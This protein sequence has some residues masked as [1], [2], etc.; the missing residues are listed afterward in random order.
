MATSR[1]RNIR[2]R[3]RRKYGR[4]YQMRLRTNYA[5]P[6]EVDRRIA[7]PASDKLLGRLAA[8]GGG[9]LF[10]G[11]VAKVLSVSRMDLTVAQVLTTQSSPS[12]V[13][14]GSLL[15]FF[16]VIPVVGMNVTL[17]MLGRSWI[18][19]SA[20]KLEFRS[21][22]H[23]IYPAAAFGLFTAL[24]AYLTPRDFFLQFLLLTLSAPLFSAAVVLIGLGARALS[25]RRARTFSPAKGGIHVNTR[26]VV[27]ALVAIYSI[28]TTFVA[29]P[30]VVND[31]SWLPPRQVEFENGSGFVGYEVARTTEFVT[32]LRE[33]NRKIVNVSSSTI[34]SAEPCRLESLLNTA[35]P[36]VSLSSRQFLMTS[37][38]T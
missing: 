4:L 35:A 36:L 8:F 17:L 26:R 3:S 31:I 34:S 38:C 30:I 1:P 19:A 25:R 37:A 16:P 20:E 10:V 27:L 11:V 18:E 22:E 24:G 6:K 13:V 32:L 28:G 29:L 12:A 23:I 15:L 9:L 2:R 21:A 5:S 33:D 14:L 7:K